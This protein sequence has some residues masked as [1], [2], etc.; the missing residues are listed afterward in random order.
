MTHG[1]CFMRPRSRPPLIRSLL[2]ALALV[3]AF[4][5]ALLLGIPSPV[6]Q[7]D[8]GSVWMFGGNVYP[9]TDSDIRMESETVQAVCYRGF[10]EYLAEFRF[11]NEGEAK[12]LQLGFPCSP[13]RGYRDPLVAFQAW[14]DG[15][16]LEV[17]LGEG[18]D[19]TQPGSLI[20]HYLHEATFPHGETM[21]TV[22]YL[23]GPSTM[24]GGRLIKDV[25]ASSGLWG[26][27][28]V[29][30]YW[31]HTGAGWRDTIG[32]AVVR[33]SLADDFEGS[34]VDVTAAEAAGYELGGAT[35]NPECYTKPDGHTYQWV[36]E[37]IEPSTK[38]DINLVYT[39]PGTRGGTSTTASGRLDDAADS[40]A[41]RQVIDR[42]LQSGW[43]VPAP[44]TGEWVEVSLGGKLS[45]REIRILP[46][47]NDRL[48]SFAEYGRPKRLEVTL[49]DGASTVLT[50]EDEPG[51]Q[52]F[53]VSGEA[54]WV[55]FE[56]LDVYPG[57]KSDDTY[58][59]EI[60]L[61]TQPAPQFE[62]FSRLITAD[63]QLTAATDATPAAA[64]TVASDTDLAPEE[65]PGRLLWP[66]ILGAVAA[67][68][69]SVVLACLAL[70]LRRRVRIPS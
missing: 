42:S 57:N 65:D 58:I 25:D 28:A 22:S 13:D 69:G 41:G 30:Q 11:V 62:A 59:S 56:I 27:A 24:N 70:R 33:Y 31:L 51:L 45:L 60:S 67:A 4:A 20:A 34:D 39:L 40:P 14:Q 17:T 35:T 32:N 49:S 7:A 55:R 48:G 21:I 61:G 19:P 15:R 1:G 64:T 2:A 37:D 6:V 44:G 36:F 46:G 66:A 26:G 8:D 18:P 38:D 52:R 50:L 9:R 43:G 3:L 53:A 16:P 23:V 5:G 63:A 29:Y 68:V 47:R 12:R 54:E 10:A